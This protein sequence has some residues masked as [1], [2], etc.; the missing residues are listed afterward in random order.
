M[1]FDM[2]EQSR[3]GCALRGNEYMS[4]VGYKELIAIVTN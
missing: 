1:C 4:K 2:I 3:L